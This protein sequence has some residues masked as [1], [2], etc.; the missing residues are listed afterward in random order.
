MNEHD[1]PGGDEPQADL[2][3][4]Q[5]VVEIEHTRADM[6]GTIDEIGHRL[7]PQT[8][9][10]QAREQV[11]EATVGRVERLVEDAGH[12][13]QQTGNIKIVDNQGN[14]RKFLDFQITPN[15]NKFVKIKILKSW[16]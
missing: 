14:K 5:I 15:I 8:I 11:R 6:S 9:A 10:E 13:A 16:M 1:Q 3:E 4:E 2:T 12:T 7:N